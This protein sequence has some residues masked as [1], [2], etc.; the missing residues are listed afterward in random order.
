LFSTIMAQY[1]APQ[2]ISG[3]QSQF[4]YSSLQQQRRRLLQELANE[5]ARREHI[6]NILEVKKVQLSAAQNSGKSIRAL[7]K[8]SLYLHRKLMS[9]EN[10]EKYLSQSLAMVTARLNFLEQTQWRRAVLQYN[11]PIPYGQ[12]DGLAA[13]MQ[14]MA[15]VSP[16]TPEFPIAHNTSGF[17]SPMSPVFIHPWTP[18]IPTSSEPYQL[19][20]PTNTLHPPSSFPYEQ[21][22]SWLPE[23]NTF[24]PAE[25]MDSS[26]VT[27][28]IDT[29]RSSLRF[30]VQDFVPAQ[31]AL[32][33][34][35][36]SAIPHL[37][38]DKTSEN[39][40]GGSGCSLARKLSLVNQPSSALRMQRKYL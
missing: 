15:L 13:R 27:Q 16:S 35:D 8:S 24:R 28:K 40:L 6:A 38:L 22:G 18:V 34:P 10:T 4:E 3:I 23:L 29:K 12:S 21:H 26:K 5:E 2:T 9:S 30:P 36:I 20:S 11:E 25:A 32:S 7:K 33:L 31:R 14:N 17:V 39:H 19:F 1:W 37:S